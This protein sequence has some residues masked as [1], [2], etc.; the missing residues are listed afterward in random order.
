MLPYPV[1]PSTATRL[2]LARPPAPPVAPVTSAPSASRVNSG[3]AVR[4]TTAPAPHAAS[5]PS[6]SWTTPIHSHAHPPQPSLS[7][8]TAVQ[9]S[10]RASPSLAQSQPT[11]SHRQDV[12]YPGVQPQPANVSRQL[13]SPSVDPACVSVTHSVTHHTTTSVEWSTG[14]TRAVHQ[15]G[16]ARPWRYSQC[17][18]ARTSSRRSVAAQSMAAKDEREVH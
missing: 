16:C 14:S 18:S 9:S 6:P 15:T 3:P 17:E 7:R 2:V 4:T 10:T 13:H 12:L 1:Y 8:P 5:T 11:G